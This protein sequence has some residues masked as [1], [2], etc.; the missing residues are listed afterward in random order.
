M[1]SP[2]GHAGFLRKPRVAAGAKRD[3]TLFDHLRKLLPNAKTQTLKRMVEA[4]R[5]RVNGAPARALKQAIEPTDRIDLAD[6]AKETKAS[7]MLPFPVI[8]EDD[9][10]LV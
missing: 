5:V 8:H 3:M 10:V 2:R 7:A 9:D 1:F 6:R 4:K